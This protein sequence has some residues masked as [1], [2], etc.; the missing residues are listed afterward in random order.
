MAT[1]AQRSK[2]VKLSVAHSFPPSPIN[3]TSREQ[4]SRIPL[5]MIVEVTATLR[6]RFNARDGRRHWKVIIEPQDQTPHLNP[7]RTAY[8]LGAEN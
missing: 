3:P 8:V 5:T 6:E 1:R 2:Q 4:R 7:K